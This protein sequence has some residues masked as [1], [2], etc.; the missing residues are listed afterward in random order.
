[1][2]P[3]AEGEDSK[4]GANRMLFRGGVPREG[5]G[6]A[7]RP[8]VEGPKECLAS[9]ADSTS[10]VTRVAAALLTPTAPL[11]PSQAAGRTTVRK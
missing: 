2:G 10:R 7:R 3:A 6:D 1:M 8:R 5:R 11:S 9:G 4:I